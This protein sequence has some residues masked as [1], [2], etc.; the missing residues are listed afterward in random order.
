MREIQNIVEKTWVLI[1]PRYRNIDAAVQKGFL[2][3]LR[4]LW[5]F[6]FRGGAIQIYCCRGTTFFRRYRIVKKKLFL[7]FL[8]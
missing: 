2:G 7:I 8:L 6:Y 5:I 4:Y 1:L 3:L